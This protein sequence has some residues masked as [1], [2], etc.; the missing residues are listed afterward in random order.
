[1]AGGDISRAVMI[2]DTSIDIAAA[3]AAAVPVVGCT[4]GYS[5]VPMETLGADAV[6]S[7]YDQLESAVRSLLAVPSIA[8]GD[9]AS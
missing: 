5:D 3:K 8:K 6:I 1:M 4:F 7:H 2:G 9:A